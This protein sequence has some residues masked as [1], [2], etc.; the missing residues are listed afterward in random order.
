MI[1]VK[2]HSY[3]RDFLRANGDR[4]F[5]HHLTMA[6]L[7][8]RA[9][10]LGSPVLMQTGSSVSKYCL[11][12]L[13]PIL[14][15]DWSVIIVAPNPTQ[16]YLLTTEI[17]LLQQWLGTSKKIRAGDSWQDGDRLLLTTPEGLVKRSLRRSN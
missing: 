11:S 12:Y 15:G 14:L 5:P 13:M 10:R 16:E 3:L 6:R 8:A 7:I 17:P 9:L 1:E 4:N 2:V